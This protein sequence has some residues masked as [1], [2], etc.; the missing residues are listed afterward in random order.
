MPKIVSCGVIVRR[1]VGE[2][3]LA[4]ATGSNYWDIPKGVRDAGETSIAAALRELRE[5]AGI[6]LRDDQL[7]DLGLHKYLPRK[8][9]HLFALDPPVPTL[10]INACSCS[11]H[12]TPRHGRREVPEVDAYRWSSRLQVPELCGKNMMRV[13]MSLDW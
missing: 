6:A 2:L 5:E 10:D 3:L 13:L 11:T 9:L 4:H 12:Y 7:L 1:A 8:D